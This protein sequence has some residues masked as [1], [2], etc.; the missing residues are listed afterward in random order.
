MALVQ[1]IIL[2]FSPCST[3]SPIHYLLILL[4]NYILIFYF[5]SWSLPPPGLA[6]LHV[7]CPA[8][9]PLLLSRT[10]GLSTLHVFTLTLS[11][12]QDQPGNPP[13]ISS[14]PCLMLTSSSFP[15]YLTSNLTKL[16]TLSWKACVICPCLSFQMHFMLPTY[17]TLP[18]PY[19]R[20]P[21]GSGTGSSLS[22]AVSCYPTSQSLFK[23]HLLKESC[24]TILNWIISVIFSL[25]FLSL[26]AF[27]TSCN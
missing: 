2:S 25:P 10:V 24:L 7:C 16:L 18:E 1:G 15:L 22:P 12:E 14:C 3:P 6:V 11:T 8:P 27:I 9:T 23:C 13:W 21:P 4:L 26:I 17:Q 5:S 19:H 20:L